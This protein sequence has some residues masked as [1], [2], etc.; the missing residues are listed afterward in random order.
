VIRPDEGAVQFAD[1]HG[2]AQLAVFEAAAIGAPISYGRASYHA[3]HS[4]IVTA[5]DGTRRWVRFSWQPTVGVLNTDPGKPPVDCYLEQD[6]RDRIA[7]GPVH[8][9]LMMVIGEV[10]DAFHDPTRPWPPHR[11]RI[12]M[13]ELTLNAILDDGCC[14]RLNFNPWL[15]T[16]GI[17]PSDDPVLKARRDAYEISG[18]RRG[19]ASCPFAMR[20]DDAR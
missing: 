13:G 1:Q 10:G 19:A 12:F 5:P 7:A 20:Q 16:K 14:E 8:F 6:L 11:Q 2:Y 17:E 4:F 9:N 18:R 15:L 3:V